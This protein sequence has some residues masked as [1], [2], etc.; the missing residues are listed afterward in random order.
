M[1]QDGDGL[2]IAVIGATGA[3][4]RDLLE[5]LSKSSLPVGAVRLFASMASVGET[6]EVDGQAHRVWGLVDSDNV[7]EVFEGVD[8]VFMAT[9]PEITR[10]FGLELAAID[11][12]VIDI[13]AALADKARLV[14]PGV[15]LSGLAD[16]PDTRIVCSP[17]GPAVLLSTVIAPLVECGAV[18]CRGTVMMSAGIAGRAGV[19]E[20][21]EQVIAMFNSKDPPRKVFPAGLAFDIH[22]N[23]EADADGWTGVERRLAVET[24]SVVGWSPDRVGLTAVIVPVFT[25]IAASLIVD[26]DHQPH[27]E[28]IRHALQEQPLVQVVDPLP[29]PRRVAGEPGVFVGRLRADPSADSIHLWAICDNLRCAASGN[30]VAIATALWSDGHL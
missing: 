12:P 24:A 10:D 7:H 15:D 30:A 22:A 5:T 4:G 9:P 2:S 13:G 3:V 26:F 27:L 17:S 8:L 29:G 11:I 21:S 1:R 20:L 18:R 28:D 14:V 23:M 16:F 25:G 6:V 19:R